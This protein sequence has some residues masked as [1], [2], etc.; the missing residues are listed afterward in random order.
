MKKMPAS[1]TQIIDY[2]HPLFSLRINIYRDSSVRRLLASIGTEQTLDFLCDWNDK[3]DHKQRI[4][5]S[6][7]STNN[8]FLAGDI[9]QDFLILHYD[10]NDRLLY[11][12]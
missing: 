8:N 7:D 11:A 3:H 2:S 1:T 9:N 4:Y 5:L 10:K 6:Y 12:K